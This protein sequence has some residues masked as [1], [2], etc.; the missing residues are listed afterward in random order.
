M[1]FDEIPYPDFGD[2]FDQLK[3]S[4]MSLPSLPSLSLETSHGCWWGEK[5]QCTFCSQNG[6]D[7]AYSA[8][9]PSRALAELEYFACKYPGLDIY[10][11]DNVLCE[12]YFDEVLPALVQR[13]LGTRLF[14]EVRAALSKAQIRL[15]RDSGVAILQPGIESL[16][17][18]LLNRMH[19]GTTLFDNLQCLKWAREFGLN[20][21][22][23]FLYGFPGEP[24]A[25]YA[26]MAELVP[27][28]THLPPPTFMVAI[29]VGRFSPLFNQ[30]AK[31][32]LKNLQPSPAYACI[33]PFE[34]DVLTNLATTFIYQLET[35][36]LEENYTQGLRSAIDAWQQAYPLSTLQLVDEGG[37]LCVHDGRPVAVQETTIFTGL[38]RDLYLACDEAQSISQ[39]QRRVTAQTG[40]AAAPDEIEQ[41]LQ[42]MLTNKLMLQ[43]GQRFL[44]LAIPAADFRAQ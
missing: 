41:L 10:A 37:R 36:Q 7:L 12:A 22:W 35:P 19:K 15:L 5:N 24:P 28:L 25:A 34:P 26:R 13:P 6:V 42:T 23:N 21:S 4:G 1:S 40:Q 18:D 31:F 16:N 27:L 3:T 8:K 39:L 33:F 14:Y 38:Q 11:T 17:T 43:E 9:S 29:L 2:Y 44:S 30:A 20:V 32:G